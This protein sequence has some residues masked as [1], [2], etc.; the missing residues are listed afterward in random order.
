M[1]NSFKY[2]HKYLFIKYFEFLF[3][4]YYQIYMIEMLIINLNNKLI[5]Y[6][7][8]SFSLSKFVGIESLNILSYG[9]IIFILQSSQIRYQKK[10]FSLDALF[11]LSNKI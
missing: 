11:I 9:K 10:D 5:R 4:I 6:Y 2:F 8:L 1:I 7:Y 3:F